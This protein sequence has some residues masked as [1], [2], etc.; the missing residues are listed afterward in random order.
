MK[1]MFSSCLLFFCFQ[2]YLVLDMFLQLVAC[3]QEGSGNPVAFRY[4]VA[5]KSRVNVLEPKALGEDVNRTHMRYSMLGNAMSGNLKHLLGW[6]L[7]RVLWEAGQYF[8]LR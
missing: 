8:F 7:L 4:T 1:L 5:P 6:D 3:M 2:P